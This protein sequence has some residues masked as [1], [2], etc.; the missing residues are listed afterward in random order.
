MKKKEIVNILKPYWLEY[1]KNN[2]ELE[3]KL[4]LE[5]FINSFNKLTKIS[6]VNL[7]NFDKYF[8]FIFVKYSLIGKFWVF[9]KVMAKLKKAEMDLN[10]FKLKY[11]DHLKPQDIEDI[12]NKK[13]IIQLEFNKKLN[14]YF[15]CTLGSPER[16]IRLWCA[17]VIYKEI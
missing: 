8:S 1:L 3:R 16:E 5:K 4:Q 12:E 11:K 9:S 2:G 13:K 6:F 10:D 14:E 7:L 15:N 17:Y